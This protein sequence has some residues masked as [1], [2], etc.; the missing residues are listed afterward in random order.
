MRA[1]RRSRRG[2]P[3]VALPSREDGRAHHRDEARHWW[4][5]RSR[6]SADHPPPARLPRPLGDP[7]RAVSGPGWS[8]EALARHYTRFR[9]YERL[10]L[11]GHSH[12]AWPDCGFEPGAGLS[13]EAAVGP[14]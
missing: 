6:V 9:V 2:V 4:L 12:Q 5:G 13:I 7:H 3:G 1:A 8:P 14:G 11:T 10:L